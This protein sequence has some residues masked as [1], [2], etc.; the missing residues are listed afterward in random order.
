MS[1]RPGAVNFEEKWRELRDTIKAVMQ[2]H[3]VRMIVWNDHY[4]YPPPPPPPPPP[5]SLIVHARIHGCHS[6]FY[7]NTRAYVHTVG[8]STVDSSHASTCSACSFFCPSAFHAKWREDVFEHLVVCLLKQRLI[9]TVI[10]LYPLGCLK[11][12]VVPLKCFFFLS[13]LPPPSDY[14]GCLSLSDSVCLLP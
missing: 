9:T 10:V 6:R 4:S 14:S 2:L 13:G 7:Q 8:S 12:N 5:P 3:S 11:N 1:L